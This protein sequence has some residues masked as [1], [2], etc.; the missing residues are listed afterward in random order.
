MQSFV[1]NKRLDFHL[2]SNKS[3]GDYDPID[4]VR[5]AVKNNL[6]LIALTDHD[7]VSGVEEAVKAGENLGV[8][9]LPGVELDLES[10]FDLHVLGL[11]VDISDNGLLSALHTQRQRRH[12]RNENIVEQLLKNGFDI[13][14]FIGSHNASRVHIALA[15]IEA[16]FAKNFG[17]AFVNFLSK[18]RPG[19]CATEKIPP[20]TG[21]KLILNANGVPVL[22]HPCKIA[23]NHH[24]LVNELVGMGLKGIEAFY[25]ASTD[26]QIKLFLSLAK[27]YGLLVT[28]GSDFHG[29]IR[30]GIVPGCAWVDCEELAYTK[31]YI[32]EYYFQ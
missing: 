13:R 14:Q 19:Y 16:G 1:M 6:S 17:E 30:Q 15:L 18:D 8:S 12:A 25:P 24:A 7:T 11:G 22:A 9:V 4:V 10:P 21:I 31:K 29:S 28:A 2:H 20:E 27:Q 23:A 5:L 3:D 26:G 32:E